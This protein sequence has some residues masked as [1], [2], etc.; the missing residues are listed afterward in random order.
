M[1]IQ[2]LIDEFNN[3]KTICGIPISAEKQRALKYAAIRM[4]EL[5]EPKLEMQTLNGYQ[6]ELLELTHELSKHGIIPEMLKERLAAMKEV[7]DRILKEQGQMFENVVNSIE[8]GLDFD[9]KPNREDD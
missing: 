3:T 8:G 6:L 4:E 9:W 5:D 2:E 7:V 1:T